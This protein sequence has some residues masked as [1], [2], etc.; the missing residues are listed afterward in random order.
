MEK[1]EIGDLIT[2][3]DGVKYLIVDLFTLDGNKYVYVISDDGKKETIICRLV[4]DYLEK[5]SS[6]EEYDKVLETLISRN[7]DEINKILEEN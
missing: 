5:L 6:K 7:K 3:D 4:D 1:Y 2:L